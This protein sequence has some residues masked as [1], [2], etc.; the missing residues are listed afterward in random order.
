MDNY[1]YNLFQ[2]GN[3]D[4]LYYWKNS[5]YVCEVVYDKKKKNLAPDS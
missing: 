1:V 3:V 5:L 4:Q 2:R